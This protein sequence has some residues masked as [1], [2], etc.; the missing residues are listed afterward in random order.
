MKT[1][2]VIIPSLNEKEAIQ[3]VVRT[4]PS[5]RLREIGY[6][7]QILVIDSSS[8]NTAELARQAGA[9]VIYEPRPGYGRAYKTGFQNAQGDVIATID[10]DMTYPVED[11]PILINILEQE[12]L[13]FISTNR[14]A[15]LEKGAMPIIHGFGNAV[16]NITAKV[17][18]GWRITDSQSGMWVFRKNMLERAILKSDSMSFSEELKIEASYYLKARVKEVPIKYRIRLG[19][20]KIKTWKHGLDNLV[21][22]TKKRIKR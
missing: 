21:F 9:K 17:L 16:L 19:K 8:D 7:T 22:L 12:Q 10:A 20:A 14:F 15:Y 13:D 11:L 4:V 2:T 1:I 6:E 18:Y 3:K 5:N